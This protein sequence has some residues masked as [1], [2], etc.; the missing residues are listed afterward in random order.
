[1][2]IGD[3][4]HIQEYVEIKSIINIMI[5]HLYNTLHDKLL[6]ISKNNT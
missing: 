1:L 5:R 4:F 2:F 6:Y 3:V